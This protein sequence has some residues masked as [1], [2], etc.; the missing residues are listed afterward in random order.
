MMFSDILLTVDYD[1][2]MTN[3]SNQIP[4]RNLD[5]I[6]YFME[7]GGT[8]T[9]N[10]GRSFP[11]SKEVLENVPMN[12]PFLGY[13]GSL[14]L[15]NGQPIN[16]YIIDLPLEETLWRICEQFPDLN[17]DLHGI[18]AHYGFQPRGCW[19]EFYTKRE[20]PHHVAKPGMDFGPFL[21]F[22]VSGPFRDYTMQQG[23]DGTDAL[24]AR[25]DEVAGW[26]EETYGDKLTI[27]RAGAT[28]LNVHAK[29]VSKLRS[30]R[31][32]QKRLGKKILICVGDEEN[33][34]AMLEGADFSFSPAGSPMAKE[35]PPV[36][37]CEEGA[38][39]D[40]IEKEIP[41]ILKGYR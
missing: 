39:A 40:V 7:N 32:L 18:D 26:L 25:I 34:R 36:C 13:N 35:F 31:D 30:A 15:D 14:T 10:T 6:R 12:A 11:M 22:N 29:G 20:C 1:R 8:F 33:D 37:S 16:P 27:L 28:F 5:A 3:Y 17:V 21:K 23:F 4:Q 38:V 19:E 2:T 41:K 9:V 24:I